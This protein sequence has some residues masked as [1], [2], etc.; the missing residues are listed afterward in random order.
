MMQNTKIK[1]VLLLPRTYNDGSEVPARL[2]DGM[3]QELFELAEGY[4]IAG[5]VHGAY[6]MK[7]GT[8]KSDKLWQIWIAIYDNEIDAL[9]QMVAKFGKVLGQ[10]SMYL[11]RTGGYVDF[12]P[13][14]S[15]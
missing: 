15:S 10:E 12:I 8:K 1:Y 13:P 9:H 14:Q 7:D 6:R 4:C 11:E 3:M 2:L 5:T